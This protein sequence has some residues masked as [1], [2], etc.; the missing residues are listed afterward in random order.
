MQVIVKCT[1]KNASYRPN[2]YRK[3][4]TL[5]DLLK[6]KMQVIVKM[7]TENVFHCLIYFKKNASYR[8][9]DYRKRFSLFDLLYKRS[10]N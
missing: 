10:P 5:F 9:N 1:I 2:E 6:K 4:F 7:I 3:R 8:Q